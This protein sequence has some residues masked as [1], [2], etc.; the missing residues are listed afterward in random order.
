MSF[1]TG[2]G[3]PAANA[4]DVIELVDRQVPEA[5][6]LLRAAGRVIGEVAADVVSILNPSLIVVGGTL[7]RGGEFLLSGVR[8]LVYQR[9]LPL[10]TRDLQIVLAT[11]QKDSALFGA[12]YLVF[13]DVFAPDKVDAVIERFTAHR[14]G[15]PKRRAV[16]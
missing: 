14:E 10:A 2:R 6:M 8:E 11:P 7:A 3:F 16:G 13:D 15:V 4:R 5:I 9:C 1:C 12:A